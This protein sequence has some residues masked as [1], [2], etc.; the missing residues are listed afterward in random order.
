MGGDAPA[1]CV[2]PAAGFSV[3]EKKKKKGTA[4]S[5]GHGSVP[6]VVVFSFE[7]NDISPSRCASC[8]FFSFFFHGGGARN[9]V[10]KPTEEI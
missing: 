5:V 6:V 3:T 9:L 2:L 8:V 1:E 7:K 10:R 4:L